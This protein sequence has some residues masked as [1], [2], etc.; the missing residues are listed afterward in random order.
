MTQLVLFG[1]QAFHAL[2]RPNVIVQNETICSS[3]G[4]SMASKL[5]SPFS[6]GALW[7]GEK[8]AAGGISGR[9]D[10]GMTLHYGFR[11]PT[12]SSTYPYRRHPAQFWSWRR[13]SGQTWPR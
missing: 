2:R 12:W 9:G 4:T 5:V 10:I 7:D 11:R 13:W 3:N 6:G 1:G 8:I